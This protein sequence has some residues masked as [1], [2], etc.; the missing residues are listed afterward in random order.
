[1]GS[2]RKL[3]EAELSADRN[4]HEEMTEAQHRRRMIGRR[5]RLAEY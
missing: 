2:M 5:I 4:D 3:L 1:M